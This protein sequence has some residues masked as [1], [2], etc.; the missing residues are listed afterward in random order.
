[1]RRLLN[2][3]AKLN[4]G[5]D[6]APVLSEYMGRMKVAGFGEKYRK[7]VLLRGLQ[8]YDKMKRDDEHQ[9]PMYRPKDWN[10]VERRKAKEKKNMAGQTKG[11]TLPQYLC[12][13]PPSS[14][15]SM[16]LLLI[17]LSSFR[18]PY[19]HEDSS[20]RLLIYD[21]IV[22]TTSLILYS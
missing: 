22:R 16:L 10:K 19:L 12:Q 6:V 11:S 3:S 13:P 15:F 21:C 2:S 17:Q 18:Q 4:W 5:T 1:M 20:S 14:A 7:S 9:R 8:I